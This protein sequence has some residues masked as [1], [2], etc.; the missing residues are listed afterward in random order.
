MP[1]VVHEDLTPRLEKAGRSVREAEL[2]L[3]AE[4]EL[5]R[6]LVVRAADQGMPQRQIAAAIGGGTGLVS[7]IL[8]TPA[9]DEDQ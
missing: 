4:R 8:A 3:A 7:K 2:H 9:P 6:Q 5:R 1:S